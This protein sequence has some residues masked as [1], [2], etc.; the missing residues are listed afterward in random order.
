VAKSKTQTKQLGLF[1]RFIAVFTPSFLERLNN[2]ESQGKSWGFWFLSNFLF[3]LLISIVFFIS[4]S[5][6]F[7]NFPNK[8]VD[9]IPDNQVIQ[10]DDGTSFN[11]KKL[12]KDFSLSVDSKYILSSKNIPDPFVIIVNKDTTNFYTNLEDIDENFAEFVFVLDT[13]NQLNLQNSKKEFN[14]FIYILNDKTVFFDGQKNKLQIIEY[15]K[16]ADGNMVFPQTINFDSLF[17]AKPFL[18]TFIFV[19]F[20][21]VMFLLYLFLSIARL[22]NAVLWAIV[23]WTIGAIA[24]VKN[25]D[26]EKSFIAMLHF[27]FV[28]MLFTPLALVLDLTIFWYSFAL[29]GILF[30]MNF[31]NMKN[32]SR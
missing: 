4:Q 32:K 27:S 31:W 18:Q 24:N 1:A 9:K 12:I 15:N 20:G 30:G 7:S 8:L 21:I 11:I 22:I 26:F 23:F 16:L 25:W 10:L 19:I 29:F 14:N 3:I 2:Q 17:L 5:I 6:F 13:K 28:T